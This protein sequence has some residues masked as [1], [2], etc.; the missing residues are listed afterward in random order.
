MVYLIFNFTLSEHIVIFHHYFNWMSVTNTYFVRIS[1][2]HI[3]CIY[4]WVRYL[5]KLFTSI[6]IVD[7]F[8]CE[9]HM[10]FIHIYSRCK[11]FTRYFLKILSPNLWLGLPFH[12]V[13]SEYWRSKL[14][15]LW[16]PSCFFL[17]FFMPIIL[18]GYCC[19]TQGK[20]CFLITVSSRCLIID[21]L[22]SRP[23][24]VNLSTTSI[25]V[26]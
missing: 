13:N 20:K 14:F 9:L 16:S 15:V 3:P 25:W 17:P 19:L 7:S 22:T 4:L 6:L 5:L 18:L 10:F 8:V 12:F 1:L 21:F 23:V 2:V 24:D 11:Y 26:G